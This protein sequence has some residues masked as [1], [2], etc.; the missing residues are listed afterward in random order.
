MTLFVH[1][2]TVPPYIH[3]FADKL[4]YRNRLYLVLHNKFDRKW[5]AGIVSPSVH[6]V[7]DT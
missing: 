7:D 1:V 3:H 6:D 4:Y 2:Y 5:P